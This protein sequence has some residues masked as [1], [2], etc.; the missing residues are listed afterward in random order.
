[1]FCSLLVAVVAVVV[2]AASTDVVVVVVIVI[3]VAVKCLIGA[4]CANWGRCVYLP[5][6]LTATARLAL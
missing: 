3:E 4:V 1:M 2:A 6:W 5:E